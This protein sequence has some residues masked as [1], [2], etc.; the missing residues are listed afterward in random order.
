MESESIANYDCG[1]R[2][3]SLAAME[4]LYLRVRG[5]GKDGSSAEVTVGMSETTCSFVVV[6]RGS[7]PFRD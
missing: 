4:E 1:Q 5:V 3:I 7:S 2:R 6:V